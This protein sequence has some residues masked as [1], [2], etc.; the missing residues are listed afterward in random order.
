M[1]THKLKI[2]IGDHEFEA[3]GSAEDVQSQFA[4]F[5]D[6]VM[7][8]Q[9]TQSRDMIKPD[10]PAAAPPVVAATNGLRLDKIM[11][12]DGRIVSLTARGGSI[13]NEILLVLFGQKR[14]R[15]NDSVTGSE[16]ISGLEQT[17][18]AVG[19]I[20]YKLDKMTTDGDVIT[21]GTRRARRYR[22]T[23]Q[24]VTKA[25]TLARSVISTVA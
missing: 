3:E 11:K 7:N 16:I 4:A 24:G 18:G 22:L 14:L 10:A 25:E 12:H 9:N 1:E 19:R 8:V 13:E 2:K 20:D 15:E 17:A 5:R 23:N 6:L 21:I